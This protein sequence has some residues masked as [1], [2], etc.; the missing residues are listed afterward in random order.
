MVVCKKD[1]KNTDV[2]FYIIY[3]NQIYLQPLQVFFY[4]HCVINGRLVVVVFETA[5]RCLDATRY[6]V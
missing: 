6:F 4:T 3:V 2:I 1:G 5:S